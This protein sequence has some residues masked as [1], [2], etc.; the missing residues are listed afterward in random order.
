[1]KAII[2]F[3]LVS[4]V[5]V[6]AVV[7]GY[8]GESNDKLRPPAPAAQNSPTKEA[9]ADV[10]FLRIVPQNVHEGKGSSDVGSGLTIRQLVALPGLTGVFVGHTATRER[11]ITEARE[12]LGTMRPSSRFD[13]IINDRIKELLKHKKIKET[14]LGVGS[15]RKN[16]EL[17]AEI[18]DIEKQLDIDL[19]DITLADLQKVNFNISYEPSI[20]I[21]PLRDEE[22]KEM[23]RQV[24]QFIYDWFVRN[25]GEDAVDPVW[26]RTLKVLFRGSVIKDKNKDNATPIMAVKIKTKKDKEIP[27]VHGFVFATSGK[28]VEGCLEVAQVVN[29]AAKRDGLQYVVMVNLKSIEADDKDRTPPEEY[30]SQIYAALADGRLDRAFIIPEIA[31]PDVELEKWLALVAKAETPTVVTEGTT[32]GEMQLEMMKRTLSIAKIIPSQ[33]TALGSPTVK[34]D[35][36]LGGGAK[37]HF[38]VPAGTSTGEDEAQTV[39]PKEA[40]KNLAIILEEVT[41]RGLRADQLPEIGQLM[42]KMGKDKLGAEATLAF[43]MALAWAAADQKGLQDYEFIRE[44]APDLASQGVPITAIQDNITNGG[45]HA[46]NSLDIQEFMI[47][48]IGK[49]TAE[50]NKMN[51]EVDRKLGLI[52]QA[53][54]LKADPDDKGVGAL[55]GKEGGYKIEDLTLEKLADIYAYADSYKI[56]N[57][58]IL[59]LKEQNA[60]VHEFVLNCQLAAIQNAGYKPS[61]SKEAGTVALALDAAATSMLVDGHNDLYNFEGRQITSEELVKIYA[62]WVKKYPIRSIEDGLGENDWEGWMNL[63]EAVGDDVLVIGDDLLVTQGGRLS[64]FIKRLEAKG[65]IDGNGKVTKKTGILIKLNQNGFLTTGI[66][67]PEKGYLGTLEV[68]RLAKKHGMAWIVSHRSKEAEPQENEVSIAA[69]AAGTNAELL[70]SGDHLSAV[71]AVKEDHLAAI[72][73]RERAKV[74]QIEEEAVNIKTSASQV[75]TKN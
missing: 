41:R 4:F 27:G 44:L 11:Y 26:G 30:V 31:A 42:L 12:K 67:D 33:T 18:E 19:K 75:E 71:R 5:F 46:E 14:H 10:S 17:K 59:A 37:G 48:P 2:S 3:V 8:A 15:V 22:V 29:D 61:T 68:I 66:D 58:D 70:K 9:V 64:E 50:S 25:Y 35:V 53:L 72:D 63:I 62:D 16:I 56:E 60:G 47:V 24:H 32:L 28:K 52:Y 34:L 45:A 54:G 39:G 55:R 21:K 6:G 65:F 40:I 57:L 23:V 51:D 38:V 43:Q 69:L 36:V 7:K 1:M 49:T 13:E 73:A 20:D 74:K